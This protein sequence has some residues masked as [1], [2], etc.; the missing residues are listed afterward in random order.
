MKPFCFVFP[1]SDTER[2]RQ[3]YT[4]YAYMCRPPA[5]FSPAPRP[6]VDFLCYLLKEMSTVPVAQ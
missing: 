4:V 2:E 5:R 1:L 3:A 6:F